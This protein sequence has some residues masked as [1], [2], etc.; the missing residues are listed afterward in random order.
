MYVLIIFKTRYK[1]RTSFAIVYFLVFDTPLV[2]QLVGPSACGVGL[3][4]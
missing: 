3:D 1:G 4:C 2:A